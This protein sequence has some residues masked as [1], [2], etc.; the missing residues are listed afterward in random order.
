MM[1]GLEI[2]CYGDGTN[3]TDC[4]DAGWCGRFDRMC[5]EINEGIIMEDGDK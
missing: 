1:N 3:C 5:E 2:K 4:T